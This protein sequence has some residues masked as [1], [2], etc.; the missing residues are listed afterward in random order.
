M[1][2]FVDIL[3]RIRQNANLQWL[4][5]SQQIVHRLLNERLAFLDE[6]NLWGAHGV[7]KT[8]LGWVLQDRGA[9]YAPR[10]KGLYRKG[11]VEIEVRRRE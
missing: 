3:N 7:G 4:T 9:V 8:F 2:R 5:P 11:Y 1:N 6:V 10:L